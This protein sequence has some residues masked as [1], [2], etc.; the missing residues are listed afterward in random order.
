M[1]EAYLI[2]IPL[3]RVLITP[4]TIPK[5][6]KAGNRPRI[7]LHKWSTLPRVKAARFASRTASTT[8]ETPETT[9]EINTGMRNIVKL[10]R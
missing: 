3:A 5:K 8:D 9:P 7:Y 6:N 1:S 10:D 4:E 2:H